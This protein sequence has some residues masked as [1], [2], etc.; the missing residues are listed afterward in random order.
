MSTPDNQIKKNSHPTP[1]TNKSV[2]LSASKLRNRRLVQYEQTE[3][4]RFEREETD[5]A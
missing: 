2:Q 5:V 4:K 3:S 1:V